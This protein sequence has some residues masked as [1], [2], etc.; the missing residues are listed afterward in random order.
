MKKRV[1]TTP[2]QK[3][4]EMIRAGA[5]PLEPFKSK[6]APWRCECLTCGREI[7]PR[8]A[9]V[10]RGQGACKYCAGRA[11]IP[12]DAEAVLRAQGLEP[13]EPY[14]GAQRP[15]KARCLSCG[16]ESSPTYGNLKNGSTCRH[17]SKT[18]VAQAR[19]LSDRELHA[20][21]EKANLALRG[22][23]DYENHRQK[24]PGL[25][26]RCERD[27][28]TT[29]FQLRQGGSGCP[30]C[31][32]KKVDSAFA[33]QVMKEKGL[34]PL[35]DYPGSGTPWRCRCERCGN[36]VTPTYG[37]ILSGQ[38][39][40]IYCG[41]RVVIPEE[42]ER[43]LIEEKK[44]QPLVPYPGSA[45]PWK[46]RCLVCGYETSPQYANLRGGHDGCLN[47]AGKW[48]DPE[49]ALREMLEAE[50]TPKGP[51]PGAG[52]KWP[53]TCN[54]C[55]RDIEPTY[56]GVRT[57]RGCRYCAEIGIDYSAPG[58]LYLIVHNEYKS[59]KIGI[60]NSNPRKK[61]YDRLNQHEKRGWELMQRWDFDLT[62]KAFRV[63][64]G[65]LEW[66]RLELG[67]PQ[68]LDVEEMPQGGATETFSSE[69]LTPAECAEKVES[70]RAVASDD[71]D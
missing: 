38:S 44:L 51:F 54:K 43:F 2:E 5:R 63:E 3:A 66:V 58:Y 27:V 26:L 37:S 52:N 56:K 17:C 60:A 67:L 14:P 48:V 42:A 70:L 21:L 23:F 28:E 18:K 12:E 11:V 20:A 33:V 6:D 24:I 9:P 25:C 8:Y 30:Y 45:K 22:E 47:C 61:Y 29:L 62:E 64:Q 39:G 69:G 46:C 65:F 4:E 71:S 49:R 68:Y 1:Y 55:H 10:H 35:T 19:K 41:Q 53:S 50:I 32:G 7:T 15:W 31:A 59:L 13:L 16:K 57:G 40:C 34:V 36:E